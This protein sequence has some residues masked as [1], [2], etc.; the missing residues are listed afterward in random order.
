[1]NNSQY[2]FN[3]SNEHVPDVGLLAFGR[4]GDWEVSV[5]ETISGPDRWF[6]QLENSLM[7]LY[8]EIEEPKVIEEMLS[9]FETSEIPLDRW[10]EGT[11]VGTFNEC[12]VTLLK[13]DEFPDRYFLCIG[14]EGNGTIRIVIAGNELHD[15]SSALSQVIKEL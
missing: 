5:D 14:G 11:R 9:Y 10:K 3:S 2:N 1:M 15:I 6:A 13:D 12:A 7:Y 4:C 8:F